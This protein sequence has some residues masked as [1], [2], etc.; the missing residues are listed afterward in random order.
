MKGGP[1]DNQR[2]SAARKPT[3]EHVKGSNCVLRFVL[4][5]DRVKMRRRMIIPI[6]AIA[7]ASPRVGNPEDAAGQSRRRRVTARAGSVSVEQEMD[8]RAGPSE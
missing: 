5:V 6:H 4:T 1:F 7:V 2:M 3:I 8:L